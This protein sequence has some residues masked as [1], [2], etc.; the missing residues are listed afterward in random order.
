M[1][2]VIQ[3]LLL[4]TVRQTGEYHGNL[5]VLGSLY[6]FRDQRIRSIAPIVAAEG[7]NCAE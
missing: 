4:P 7:I 1:E 3:M 6:R 2:G 5:R